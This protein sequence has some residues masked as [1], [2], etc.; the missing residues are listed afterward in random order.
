MKYDKI[1]KKIS[2]MCF[3]YTLIYII[4]G[5]ILHKFNMQY[6]PWLDSVS[7]I[8]IGPFI[9]SFILIVTRT[10]YNSSKMLGKII[11]NSFLIIVILVL[12]FLSDDIFNPEEV[13][14]KN[15]ELK[16]E[17]ME[18]RFLMVDTI[19]YPYINLFLMGKKGTY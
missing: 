7:F 16:V 3:V 2:K 13:V 14:Y 18:S 12:I 1:I 4:S 6:R 5:F 9:I 17:V 10:F 19:Y 11:R 15:G 8:I